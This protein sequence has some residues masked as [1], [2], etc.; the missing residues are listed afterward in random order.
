MKTLSIALLLTGLSIGAT[1]AQSPLEDQSVT[2][3]HVK[4]GEEPQQ[5]MD[6]VKADFPNSIVTDVAFLPHALYGHEW[7][8]SENKNTDENIEM[9]Y[10]RVAANSPTLNYTAVYNKDGKLLSFKEIVKQALLPDAVTKTISNQ[11]A[12]WKIV[13]DQERIQYG[14]SSSN[15]YRVE[16]AKG[17]ARE[18]VFF[19]S[20]GTVLRKVKKIRV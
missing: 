15:Y 3:T 14:K 13:G 7:A 2:I 18:K 9:L 17:K 19:D 6:A 16:L 4:K 5:V 8:V 11:F 1:Q 12:D 10:Y 20:N